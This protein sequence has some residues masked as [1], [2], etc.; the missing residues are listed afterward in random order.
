MFG[1]DDRKIKIDIRNRT[2]LAIGGTKT[3]TGTWKS[4]PRNIYGARRNTG[5]NRKFRN[6]NGQILIRF[7]GDGR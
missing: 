7:Q 6:R 1:I 3:I 5:N 4:K 2:G